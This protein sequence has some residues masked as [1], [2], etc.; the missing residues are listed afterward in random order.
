MRQSSSKRVLFLPS[1]YSD[2]DKP[3]VGLFFKAQAKALIKAGYEVDLVYVEP[4]SLRAL[5]PTNIL[6]SHWQRRCTV[7]DGILITRMHGWNPNMRTVTGGL[8]WSWMTR[9]L[10]MHHIKR[11]G[12]PSL[13]HAHNLF[14]AGHAAH[15]LSKRLSIPYVVTE[16]SSAFLESG[17]GRRGLN[18]VSPAAYGANTLL[19][20]SK[21]LARAVERKIP[22]A[23]VNVLP[24][25]VDVNFF[26]PPRKPGK[27]PAFDVSS[28]GTSQP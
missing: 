12:T 9:A 10:A 24:N 16:H 27:A 19:A 28:R 13:I 3:N 5:G 14:W 2:P 11:H 7:E 25:C 8:I 23:V 4:R 6:A 18:L 21:A 15:L 26:S 17:L 1:F 20:V 22:S